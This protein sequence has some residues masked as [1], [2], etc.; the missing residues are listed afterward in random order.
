[1]SEAALFVRKPR[2]TARPYKCLKVDGFGVRWFE[3][4]KYY[5]R[6]EIKAYPSPEN[7]RIIL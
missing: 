1:M 7:I 6:D 5:T 4:G 2:D 3:P